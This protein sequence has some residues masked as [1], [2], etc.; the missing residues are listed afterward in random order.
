MFLDKIKDAFK[1]FSLCDDKEKQV[2]KAED[3]VSSGSK[4]KIL[5]GTD[6]SKLIFSLFIFFKDS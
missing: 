2:T 5:F 4:L 3:F 6:S 1:N